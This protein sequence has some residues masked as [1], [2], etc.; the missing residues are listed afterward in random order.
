MT[1]DYCILHRYHI[2]YCL[3]VWFCDGYHLSHSFFKLLTGEIGGWTLFIVWYHFLHQRCHH[4]VLS[5]GTQRWTLKRK[6]CILCRSQLYDS[7]HFFLRHI[8]VF[9]RRIKITLI[10]I[11]PKNTKTI[12]LKKIRRIVMTRT[13][14]NKP[15]NNN[16]STTASHEIDN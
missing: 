1:V 7:P 3:H 5:E 4:R 12:P 9:D 8:R 6:I 11:P 16:T 14:T 10:L 13:I 2:N 15:H